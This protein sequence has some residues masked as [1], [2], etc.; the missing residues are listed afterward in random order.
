VDLSIHNFR[1]TPLIYA[2]QRRSLMLEELA[3]IDQEADVRRH[4][5]VNRW[6]TLPFHVFSAF[7]KAA[8]TPL[9]LPA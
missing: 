5:R 3:L 7:A 4:F 1:N 8:R 6:G 9:T 2:Q